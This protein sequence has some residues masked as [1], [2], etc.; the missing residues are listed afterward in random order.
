MT[1]SSTPSTARPSFNEARLQELWDQVP[2]EYRVW[3][4]DLNRPPFDRAVRGTRLHPVDLEVARLGDL[5]APGAGLVGV[6]RARTQ[7]PVRPAGSDP[8]AS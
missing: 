4:Y 5:V 1:A 2:D 7:Q 3:R 8:T 6:V